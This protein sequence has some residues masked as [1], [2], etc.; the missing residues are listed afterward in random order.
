MRYQFDPETHVV[1][2]I[3]ETN[4]EN[5]TVNEAVTKLRSGK[6]LH[7]TGCK[8][9]GRFSDI[10]YQVNFNIGGEAYEHI[11]AKGSGTTRETRY[12]GGLE[13][14]L[15]AR[16]ATELEGIAILR[17]GAWHGMNY[18]DHS[19]INGRPAIILAYPLCPHCKE[20][21][22][23]RTGKHLSSSARGKFCCNCFSP[24]TT[25]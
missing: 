22:Q 2:I 5:D 7:Y 4:Q 11:E 1:A 18:Y 17:Y 14:Q 9:R 16:R 3:A 25:S 20:K 8:G 23:V 21:I 24:M 6:D 19:E 13:L 10:I 12:R 15:R